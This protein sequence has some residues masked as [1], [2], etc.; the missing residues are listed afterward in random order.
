MPKPT[1]ILGFA[2]AAGATMGVHSSSPATPPS[3]SVASAP[4]SVPP[5]ASPD[6]LERRPADAYLG[7]R[8]LSASGDFDEDGRLDEAFFLKAGGKNARALSLVVSFGSPTKRDR[9][10]LTFE[11][12]DAAIRNI[13]LKTAPSGHLHGCVY[14]GCRRPLRRG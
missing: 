7:N 8:H 5:V 12:T 2:L 1:A 11:E 6:R 10:V 9:I 4:P 14:A 3:D 13:G